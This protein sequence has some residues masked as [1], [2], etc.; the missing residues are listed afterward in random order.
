[1][2]DSVPP[3]PPP[4]APVDTQTPVNQTSGST[5]AGTTYTRVNINVPDSLKNFGK[6][7][8]TVASVWFVVAVIWGVVG[9]AGLIT[10]FVCLGMEGGTSVKVGGVLMAVFLGPFYWIYF[11]V[12][13]S[14]KTYCMKKV[15]AAAEEVASTVAENK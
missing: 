7:A 15:V 4:P 8:V 1:M 11:G 3:P 2:V 9:L 14:Q 5:V 13:K 6:T 12:L 10:S